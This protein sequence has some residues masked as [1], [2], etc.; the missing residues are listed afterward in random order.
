MRAC[1]SNVNVASPLATKLQA[2]AKTKSTNIFGL[3]MTAEEGAEGIRNEI[4]KTTVMDD[5]SDCYQSQGT[6]MIGFGYQ[7]PLGRKIVLP[8]LSEAIKDADLS[9]MKNGSKTDS[10]RRQAK[11]S[12]HFKIN[13]HKGSLPEPTNSQLI[14]FDALMMDDNEHKSKKQ[15]QRESHSRMSSQGRS[16]GSAVKLRKL[17]NAT[18]QQPTS[19]LYKLEVQTTLRGH[20][21]SIQNQSLE[22][23][24]S[25]IENQRID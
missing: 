7:Q 6:T 4:A 12:K 1:Q 20:A 18:Q 9:S 3:Q 22:E 14:N 25:K 11:L 19:Q 2:G 10:S 16:I 8:K 23:D 13:H 17:T 15:S 24:Y 5:N 21:A